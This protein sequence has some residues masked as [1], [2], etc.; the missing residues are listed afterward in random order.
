VNGGEAFGMFALT[1]WS[2]IYEEEHNGSDLVRW[3]IHFLLLAIR[4]I[5]L[6]I[7]VT[8]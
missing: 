4:R 3:P 6:G 7:M 2:G 8:V 1:L 5:F